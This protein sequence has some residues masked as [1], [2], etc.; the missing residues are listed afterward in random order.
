MLLEVNP[1]ISTQSIQQ[2]FLGVPVA[3]QWKRIRLG[4]MASRSVGGGSGVAMSCGVGGRRGSD[5]ALPWLWCRPAAV[6]LIRPPNLG[7]S[8]C[9]GCSPKKD[10]KKKK[11]MLKL[12]IVAFVFIYI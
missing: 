10:K 3:A 6:A 9:R 2:P 7:T 12:K 1:V 11:K 4:T 8:I 5:P